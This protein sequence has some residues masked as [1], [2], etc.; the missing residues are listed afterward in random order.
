MSILPRDKVFL[1]GNLGKDKDLGGK[2]LAKFTK[3]KSH[4][5]Y[6]SEG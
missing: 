4:F 2:N 3:K 5:R 6:N 1:G